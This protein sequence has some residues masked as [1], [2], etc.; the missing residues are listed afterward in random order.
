MSEEGFEE[1]AK[2]AVESLL[3]EASAKEAAAAEIKADEEATKKIRQEAAEEILAD[4][5]S[6]SELAAIVKEL[7]QENKDLK[8]VVLK[9]KAQGKAHIAEEKE[10]NSNENLK[11]IYGETLKLNL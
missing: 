1:Q 6:R 2:S 5:V 4:K 9:A 10:H 8:T 3:K 7:R 11:K